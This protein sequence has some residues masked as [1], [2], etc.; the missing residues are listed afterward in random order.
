VDVTLE[1]SLLLPQLD[2]ETV[3]ALKEA[4]GNAS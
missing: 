1:S 3:K 4:M 2:E